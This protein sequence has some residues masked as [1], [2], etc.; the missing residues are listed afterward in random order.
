MAHPP[1]AEALAVAVG[2]VGSGKV[3]E[4]EGEGGGGGGGVGVGVGECVVGAGVGLLLAGG[5]ALLLTE[6]LAVGAALVG[7]AGAVRDWQVTVYA[8]AT[9]AATAGLVTTSCTPPDSGTETWNFSGVTDCVP[10]LL[11]T[12]WPGVVFVP[13]KRCQ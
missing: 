13:L 12:S 5:D 6:A 4:G 9:D 7:A 3:G 8:S 11:K 10:A 1:V 2:K